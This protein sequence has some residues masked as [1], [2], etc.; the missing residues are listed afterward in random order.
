[1]RWLEILCLLFLCVSP[2]PQEICLSF[3]DETRAEGVGAGKL[4]FLDQ[5]S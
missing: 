3:R 2:K 4:A 5:H 1:M